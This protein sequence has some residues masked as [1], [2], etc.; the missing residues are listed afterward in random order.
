[1]AVSFEMKTNNVSQLLDEL[2]EKKESALEA[3]GQAAE[4]YAK[5]NLEN[6]PRRVDTGTLRGSIG[7]APADEDTMC[8]GTD[9]EYAIYVELGTLKMSPSH[10]LKRSVQD[11]ADEYMNVI[12]V[13]MEE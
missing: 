7:H 2:R 3:V 1:M 4:T 12:K 6:D 9:I 11:H 13:H 10:Y 5:L 8:V